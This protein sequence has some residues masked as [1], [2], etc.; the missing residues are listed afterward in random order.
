MRKF[1]PAARRARG[2]V[3][4]LLDLIPRTPRGGNVR[5]H[6]TQK[7]FGKKI[8]VSGQRVARFHSGSLIDADPRPEEISFVGIKRENGR[9]AA[10]LLGRSP[11][12]YARR[13]T[14]VPLG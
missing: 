8:D 5:A 6:R 3:P 2:K 4:I 7:Y 10:G 12:N 13:A 9:D 14:K 11:A 1:T